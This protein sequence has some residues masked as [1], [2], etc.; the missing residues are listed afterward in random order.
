MNA[1]NCLPKIR[2]HLNTLNKEPEISE[3]NGNL[4]RGKEIFEFYKTGLGQREENKGVLG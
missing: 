4:C 2:T 1:T 3:W